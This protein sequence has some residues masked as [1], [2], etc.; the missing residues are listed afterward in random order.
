MSVDSGVEVFLGFLKYL[1]FLMCSSG[2]E[3]MASEIPLDRSQHVV[4][5]TVTLLR[6]TPLSKGTDLSVTTDVFEIKHVG[7]W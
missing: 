2:G 1:I 4:N 5:S 6:L 7:K 3:E